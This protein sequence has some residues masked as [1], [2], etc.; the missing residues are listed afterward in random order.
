M[1][2]TV[3][4]ADE[5]CVLGVTMVIVV[6]GVVGE[7]KTARRHLLLYRARKTSTV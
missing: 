6:V 1:V 3:M 4:L 7:Q 2:P 5:A